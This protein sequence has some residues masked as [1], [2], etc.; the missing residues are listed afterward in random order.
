MAAEKQQKGVLLLQTKKALAVII[1]EI[2]LIV[3]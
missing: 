2:W 1:P 3:N